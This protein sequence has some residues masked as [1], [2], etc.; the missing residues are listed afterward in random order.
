[1]SVITLQIGQCG[2]QLGYEFFNALAE[3]IGVGQPEGRHDRDYYG[4]SSER[5][6]TADPQGN[7]LSSAVLV[8][9]EQKVCSLSAYTKTSISVLVTVHFNRNNY[10][11]TDVFGTCN[12]S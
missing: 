11:G 5:F 3:D 6:F 1:M 4:L 8:D 7:L 10:C 12:S 9:T 2:N